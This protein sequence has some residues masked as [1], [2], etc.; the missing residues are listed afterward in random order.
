MLPVDGPLTITIDGDTFR[1]IP[2]VETWLWAASEG[3]LWAIFPGYEGEAS[4]LIMQR[5]ED[6]ID[7]LDYE[8]V[9]EITKLIIE[10]AC[11]MRWWRALRL[12]GAAYN[13]WE[14]V[15]M[16]TVTKGIDLR[17]EPVSRICSITLALMQAGCRDESDLRSLMFRLNAAPPGEQAWDSR[18]EAANYK[19]LM[20]QMGDRRRG[21]K[22]AAA[23][24]ADGAAA[25][26]SA[27][28]PGQQPQRP[29]EQPPPS[30]GVG[31]NS[32]ATKVVR[33]LANRP[34]VNGEIHLGK[35]QGSDN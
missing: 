14:N 27:A 23:G 10:R 26:G 29:P 35:P 1:I 3:D 32:V 31:L 13:S 28:A 5:L 24:A 21:I 7:T 25:N 22:P 17:G 11:G 8:G 19:K 9:V 6:K 16:F 12:L 33:E 20:A 4:D 18:A 2:D 30:K 15:D 34:D